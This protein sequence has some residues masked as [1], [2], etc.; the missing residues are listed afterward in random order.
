M[1]EYKERDNLGRVRKVLEGGGGVGV[2]GLGWRGWG[3]EEA[4]RMED[5]LAKNS[6]SPSPYWRA[7]HC[8]LSLRRIPR[9]SSATHLRL[10]PPYTEFYA[11]PY[12]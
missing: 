10:K 4:G 11:A 12:L 6:V 1:R 7:H 8:C 3:E 5:N 9:K 2:E